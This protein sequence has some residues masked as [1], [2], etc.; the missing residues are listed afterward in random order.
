LKLRLVTLVLFTLL[1]AV[2]AFAQLEA[3]V[4]LGIINFDSEIAD[5]TEPI[6]RGRVGW[7]ITPLL[8]VEGEAFAASTDLDTDVSGFFGNAIFNFGGANA[9]QPYLLAGAGQVTVESAPFLGTSSIEDE[10]FAWQAAAGGRWYFTDSRRWA[11]RFQAGVMNEETFD[12]SSLH[13]V[14]TAGLSFVGRR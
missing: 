10:S 11:L 13:V 3:G 6:F 1:A 14:A 12:E 2:P 5:G 7:M 9:F 8:E 4:D